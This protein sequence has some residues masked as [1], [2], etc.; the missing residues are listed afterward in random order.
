MT[1]KPRDADETRGAGVSPARIEGFQPSQNAADRQDESHG[2]PDEGETPAPREDVPAARR[3]PQLDLTWRRH[4]LSAGLIMVALAAT[5]LAASLSHR[6]ADVLH[7]TRAP[8]DVSI[9][10]DDDNVRLAALR[11]DPNTATAAQLQLLPE[12]GPVLAQKIV[13]TRETLQRAGIDRPFRRKTDLNK[14]PGI[15]DKTIRRF[16]EHIDLPE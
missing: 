2:Q 9:P 6:N 11:L 4:N 12:I 7:S 8:G 1:D 10:I 13:A 15:G 14:V 3:G 16:A 5:V